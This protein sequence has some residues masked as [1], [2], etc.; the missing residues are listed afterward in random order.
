MELKRS[1]RENVRERSGRSGAR[2]AR[3]RPLPLKPREPRYY[4]IKLRSSGLL[5]PQDA[6]RDNEV[7]STLQ[8][9][10]TK[11]TYADGG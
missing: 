1:L 6:E 4:C 5:S 9:F 11:K 3:S 2:E 7:Y 10:K 8:Y